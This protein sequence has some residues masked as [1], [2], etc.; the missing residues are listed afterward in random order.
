MSGTPAK[1]LAVTVS[2]GREGC[3]ANGGS[4]TA[5]KCLIVRLAGGAALGRPYRW[6]GAPSYSQAYC[7]AL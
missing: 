4:L 7:G 6:S 3:K 1:Y 2:A 5:L